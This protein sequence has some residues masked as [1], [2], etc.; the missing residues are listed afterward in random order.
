[1]SEAGADKASLILAR[2]IGF[3]AE[4]FG[5]AALIYVIRWW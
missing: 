1:M 3:S 5:L 4:L 2:A